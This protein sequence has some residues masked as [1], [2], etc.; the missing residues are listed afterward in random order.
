MYIN[1]YVTVNSSFLH[2]FYE[3]FYFHNHIL[4]FKNLPCFMII[5]II[6]CENNILKLS[7]IL[8]NSLGRFSFPWTTSFFLGICWFL[9]SV[10]F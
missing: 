8:I 3:L 5:A 2:L 9:F 1:I 7:Y 6:F 4:F 10:L